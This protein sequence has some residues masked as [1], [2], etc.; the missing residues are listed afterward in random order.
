MPSLRLTDF[1]FSETSQRRTKKSVC[2]SVE[3][4]YSVAVNGPMTVR[5]SVRTGLV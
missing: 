5:S 3:R 1:P 4:R 2:S